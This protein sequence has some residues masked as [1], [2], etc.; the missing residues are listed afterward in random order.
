M[1]AGFNKTNFPRLHRYVMVAEPEAAAIYTARYLQE[2][3]SKG[4]KSGECF[5]LCDAGG[6]TV[7]VVNNQANP[8]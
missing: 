6:G 8:S 4:L 5:I 7:I 2:Q 3:G 1:D